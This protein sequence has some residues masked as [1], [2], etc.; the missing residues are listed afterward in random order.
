MAFQ[1]QSEILACGAV[2]KGYVVV[3]NVVE[4]MNFF[5][6]QHESGGDGVHWSITPSLVEE[7]TIAVERVKIV[8]VSLGSQPVQVANFEVRP[9]STVSWSNSQQ[10]GPAYEVAVVIRISSI[11]AQEFQ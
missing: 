5:L 2:S 3:C 4:E 8:D 11:V 1:F 7:T 9:L 6:L 10:T